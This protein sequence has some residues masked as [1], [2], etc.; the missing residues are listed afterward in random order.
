MST[1][2]EAEASTVGP[3]SPTA[4]SHIC[5]IESLRQ[6]AAHGKHL[7]GLTVQAVHIPAGS[8]DWA[9]ADVAGLS[10]VGCR[11]DDPSEAAALVARGALVVPA[12]EGLPYDPFRNNLYSAEELLAPAASTGDEWT[13]DEAIWHHSQETGGPRCGLIDALARRIHDHAIDDAL[14]DLLTRLGDPPV[15]GIMGGH[16]T[17]RDDPVYAT[18]AH[19]AH[20]LA[21]RGFLVATGGGPGSMEAGNLG[22]HLSTIE[23]SSV[24]DEAIARLVAAPHYTDDGYGQAALDVLG[25]HPAGAMSIAIPTWFY[26]H[27]PTNLFASAVA[28]YFANSIREDRLLAMAKGGVVFTPG[29]AGTAQEVFQDAAQNHY[30][31][32]GPASP[33]VFV[34][35]DHWTRTGLYT[36][37]LHQA[38]D[39]PYRSL[40]SLVDDSA[41]AVEEVERGW[42]TRGA[43]L[44]DP[45][46]IPAER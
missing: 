14:D 4:S 29:S 1:S 18:V 6:L 22:A 17:R 40:I 26:G 9:S 13:T 28:K 25:D 35:I 15:V 33:M 31:T 41:T 12:I 24:I 20:A 21:R 32:F 37:L 16:S 3:M 44:P 46:P 39:K 30:E 43:A 23:D 7:G 42:T 8:I 36:A 34:G 45:R 38:G 5:E 2:N 10:L 19:T 11:F 27:E